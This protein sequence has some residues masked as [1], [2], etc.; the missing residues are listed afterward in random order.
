VVQSTGLDQFPEGKNLLSGR[1]IYTVYVSLNTAKDWAMYFCIPGEKPPAC[2]GNQNVL[3]PTQ[4]ETVRAPYPTKII[5]P[6]ISVPSYEKHLLVHGFVAAY[7]VSSVPRFT[8]TP[9][10]LSIR[11]VNP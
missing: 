9:A 10:M 4:P 7:E 3:K 5:R 11:V 8:S 1:P 2:A 6:R